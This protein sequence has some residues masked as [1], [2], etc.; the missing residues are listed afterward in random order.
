[1]QSDGRDCDLQI[2]VTCGTLDHPLKLQVSQELIKRLACLRQREGR[3]LQK[4]RMVVQGQLIF[5][6]TAD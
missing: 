4:M 2:F 1:M 5:A 6:P 3:M